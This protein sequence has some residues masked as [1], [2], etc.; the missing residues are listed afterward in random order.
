MGPELKPIGYVSTE[1]KE[2]PRTWQ[3]SNAEGLL[4]IDE[5][6]H[7]GLS[8]IKTGDRLYVI[9]QFH[10]SPE[11]SDQF[12]RIKPPVSDKKKGVFSTHSPIRPNPI[13]LSILEVLGINA[14]KIRIKGLDMMDGTPILDIKPLDCPSETK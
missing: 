12:M 14:N 8:D 7:Q 3:V 1:A 5:K 13:G 4:I 2:I 9:F 10:K 6:Y 11:F